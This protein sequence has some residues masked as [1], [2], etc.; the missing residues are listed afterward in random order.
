MHRPGGTKEA[1]STLVVYML[2]RPWGRV[3]VGQIKIA[4][5][6]S[7]YAILYFLTYKC[8]YNVGYSC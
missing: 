5:K 2:K 7:Y 3:Y 4:L 8:C 6:E 1:S